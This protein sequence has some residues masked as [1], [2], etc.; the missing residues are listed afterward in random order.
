LTL[1]HII[2]E[3]LGG[4]WTTLACAVCNNGHGHEIE[5][6]LLTS[7]RFTDW[8]AGRGTMKVRMG[9]GGK[10]RAESRRDPETHHLSFEVTTPMVSPAVRVHK[11]RLAAIP[12]NPSEGHEFKVTVL[13]RPTDSNLDHPFLVGGYSHLTPSYLLAV[14][15]EKVVVLRQLAQECHDLWT[16]PLDS[17]ASRVPR[18]DGT[19][20]LGVRQGA[21]TVRCRT[22]MA[23]FIGR[24]SGSA[25]IF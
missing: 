16:L 1:A 12:Q 22:G 21:E 5:V 23:A 20:R 24:C 10:V 11:E 2:P 19:V 14:L 9:E 7:H 8:A 6:D 4:T 17:R 15:L 3:S 18:G 13:R 25:E